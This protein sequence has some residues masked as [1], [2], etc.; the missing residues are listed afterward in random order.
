M[1]EALKSYIET[2]ILPRYQAFDKGHGL[3][4]VRTV[5]G[6]S[7]ELAAHYDVDPDLVYTIAAYHDLGL[8]IDRAT[9]HSESARIL[10]AD[11]KLRQWFNSEQLQLMAE[12][13]ADHRASSDHEPRSIYG[14]IV[15]EADRDI[16]PQR[17]LQRTVQYGLT[18]Y[19][20]YDREGHWERFVAHL[21]EKYAEGGYLKLW[22]PESKNA[23]GLAELR[24]IIANRAE[25][26]RRFDYFFDIE[27]SQP[28]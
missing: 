22:I 26:R 14:K 8:E 1:N 24:R 21:L 3:D 15:A 23:Q 7:L 10:L 5:I 11:S 16:D 20:Q 9:H 19:P 2:R 6:N 28:Q 12:A 18:H 13:V 27:N 17:I 25:L 4:H